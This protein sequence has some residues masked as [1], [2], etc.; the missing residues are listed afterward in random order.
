[1]VVSAAVVFLVVYQDTGTQLQ[2]QID[3]DITGDT[4]QL[5]QSLEALNGRASPNR[6]AAARYVRAQPYNATSTLLFVLMPGRPRVSNH[7]ELFGGGA[8]RRARREPSSRARTP[9]AGRCWCRTSAT[10]PCTSRMSGAMRI[11][12]RRLGL[13]AAG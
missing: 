5:L 4:I 3:H 2:G 9:R 10:R 7:P 12:E 8:P 6:A 1:M 13:G 11:F